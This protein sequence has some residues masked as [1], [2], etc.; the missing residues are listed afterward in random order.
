MNIAIQ[1]EPKPVKFRVRFKNRDATVAAFG[2]LLRHDGRFSVLKKNVF[3]FDYKQQLQL[4]TEN[5]I[6]FE[7]LK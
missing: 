2:L 5:Q 7:I 1:F 6:P 3:G 4:L